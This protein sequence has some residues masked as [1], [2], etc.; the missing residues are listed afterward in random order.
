MPGDA[1]AS[2]KQE[3]DCVPRS[4]PLPQESPNLK[5]KY[6]PGVTFLKKSA[7]E[8]WGIKILVTPECQCILNTNLPWLA[9]I[10][11]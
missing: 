10:R 2:Q 8:V 9:D 4:S 5:C 6:G 1:S 3:R 11:P 7:F